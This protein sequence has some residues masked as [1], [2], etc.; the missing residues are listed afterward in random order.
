MI[1]STLPTPTE[2]V[3]LVP[4]L[5]S[6][7]ERAIRAWTERMAVRPLGDRYAVDSESGATYV[8]DPGGAARRD[9]R[10]W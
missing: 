4:D 2:K 7:S 10:R 8:V 5:R 1:N 9:D 6:L 3:A